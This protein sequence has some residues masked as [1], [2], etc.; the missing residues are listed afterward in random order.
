MNCL[1]TATAVELVQRADQRRRWHELGRVLFAGEPRWAPPLLAYERWLFDRRHPWRRAGADVDRMLVRRAGRVVGRIAVHHRGSDE[2]AWFGGFEADDDAEAVAALIEAAAGWAAE[3]GAA[4]L[5]GPALFTPA[6]GDA[7][8]LVDG[9]DHPGGTG[10]PWHPP[11]S[12]EQLRAVGFTPEGEPIRRWRLPTAPGPSLAPGDDLPP[13][14]ARLADPALVLAGDEGAV[15][16]VP[17]VSAVARGTRL[18]R[19][20][21]PTEAA[22]VRCEGDPA[23]LVPALLA[24]AHGA[25]YHR[26]W[27]PWSPDDARPPDTV[28]RL[29]GR[30]LR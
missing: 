11:R 18:R 6:D 5:V 16:A 15:A 30:D 21:R 2:T 3:R 19:P 28:H 17:D 25:G 1:P 7:G 9:F 13:H 10:R 20:A 29:V 24:A 26:V 23:V 4:R 27:A 22:V 12:I 14:A 8:I